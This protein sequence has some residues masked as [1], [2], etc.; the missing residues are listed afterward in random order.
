[1]TPRSTSVLLLCAA[2]LV[3]GVGWCVL[4]PSFRARLARDGSAPYIRAGHAVSQALSPG[5]DAPSPQAAERH[6]LQA[7]A[8]ENRRLRASLG[9]AE[10]NPSLVP[11]EVISRGGTDAWRQIVRISRGTRN[12]IREGSPVLAPEGLVG[13]VLSATETTSDVLLLSDPNNH[14]ACQ[15]ADGSARP[16]RGVVSG[17]GPATRWNLAANGRSTTLRL[18]YLASDTLPGAGSVLVTSGL[19]GIYPPGL[20]IGTV[21]SLSAAED[22]YYWTATIVPAAPLEA[23]HVVFVLSGWNAAP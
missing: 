11:A 7:Y 6:L 20:P 17:T 14:V 19:G 10:R 9:F 3:A 5:D 1:M 15:V 21:E 13:Y 12:D 2:L 8:E 18:D 4:S 23:L 16:V 22:G